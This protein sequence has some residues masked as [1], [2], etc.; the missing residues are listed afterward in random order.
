MLLVDN[1][2]GSSELIQPLKNIGLT[3]EATS[4]EFGDIL[5]EGRGVAGKP[6]SIAV[7][8]K[9][10]PELVTS[11]RDARLADVQATGMM[12]SFDIRWLLVQGDVLYDKRGKL[13]RRK[14]R[15][16]FAPMYGGMTIS[17][18]YKRLFVLQCAMGL[19]FAIVRQRRDT[20][21]WIEAL[22]RTWTD[23]DLDKHKSH[24]ALYEPPTLVPLSQF[25]RTV[26]TLPNV[27][28]AT[29]LALEKQFGSLRRAFSAPPITW[30]AVQT[31]DDKGHT[32]SFG[33]KHAAHV[34]AALDEEHH[35]LRKS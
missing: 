21:K 1:R 28:I 2:A 24:L 17:E 26:R 11:L 3:V 30:A 33:H 15:H 12:Q 20:L 32:R 8:Y 7:E 27:G 22:Y 35:G 5:F 29:S 34:A 4:L 25:R 23:V 10:L 18:L 9:K 31:T 6:L 14:G 13:M 19:N 16:G